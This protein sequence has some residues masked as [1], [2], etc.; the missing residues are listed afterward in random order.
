MAVQL[1]F[2]KGLNPATKAM[3]LA[4]DNARIINGK[5]VFLPLTHPGSGMST[6]SFRALL[7]QGLIECC[8]L[9]KEQAAEYGTHSLKIG[10]IELLR[11]RGVNQELRQQ[12]GGWMS[13]AVALRYLQLTPSIQFDILKSL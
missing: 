6:E 12:L 13:S 2:L 5:P 7:R 10:A 11:S 9:T 4:R 8:G 1:E 3:F